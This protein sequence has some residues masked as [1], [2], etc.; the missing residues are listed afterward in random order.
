MTVGYATSDGTAEAGK[1]YTAVSGA[2]T[3]SLSAG[4]VQV[5]SVPMED[6]GEDETAEET[7]S[8][9]LSNLQGDDQAGL[10]GG[11][12]TLAVTGTIIDDDARAEINFGQAEYTV[13]EGGELTVPVAVSTELDPDLVDL[14]Q[15]QW[16]SAPGPGTSLSDYSVSGGF[17][18][19]GDD[20]TRG[21]FFFTGGP[22]EQKTITF[23]AN[24][25][26]V[27]DDGET[28]ALSFSQLSSGI[29]LGETATAMVAIT[30]DYDPKV[31]STSPSRPTPRPRAAR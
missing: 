10:I 26:T 20:P 17:N 18:R 14:Q 31:R 22:A 21:W 30:D 27:D 9:T 8:L 3:F 19:P 16:A 15:A 29:S 1:D 4:T 12:T 2:L 5:V 6:D 25:D 24:Q 28:V 13:A 23:T 11:E 7:F